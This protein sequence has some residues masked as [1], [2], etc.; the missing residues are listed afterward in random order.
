MPIRIDVNDTGGWTVFRL[1]HGFYDFEDIVKAS[2]CIREM[3]RAELA[4]WDRVQELRIQME[5]NPL[6][7]GRTK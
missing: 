3:M 6:S 5:T 2:R 1:G 4:E 7:V